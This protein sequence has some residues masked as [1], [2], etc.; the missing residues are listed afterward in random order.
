M[1]NAG[2]IPFFAPQ[3]IDG[4]KVMLAASSLDASCRPVGLTVFIFRSGK[5]VGMVTETDPSV[6]PSI[7]LND[8]STLIVNKEVYM[9]EDPRC[10]P[11]G[12]KTLAVSI[13]D[14]GISG[15]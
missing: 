5:A 9:P 4:T 8:A 12:K 10:C 15:Q 6:V 7:Q 13:T 1:V 3:Q 14:Q 2:W 11:S